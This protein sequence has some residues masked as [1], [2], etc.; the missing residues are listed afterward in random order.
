MLADP[1]ADGVP[2]L[3]EYAQGLLPTVHDAATMPAAG[4]YPDASGE[5]RLRGILWP[6]A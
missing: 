1:D 5:V 4:L 3:M 6:P 2:L